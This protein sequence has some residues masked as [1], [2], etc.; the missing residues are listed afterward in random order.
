MQ[1]QPGEL[2]IYINLD[3]YIWLECR[4]RTGRPDLRRVGNYIL[5]TTGDRRDFEQFRDS[6]FYKQRPLIKT[7]LLEQFMKQRSINIE[8][9]NKF[10][11][12]FI[13][14]FPYSQFDE[15]FEWARKKL[16]SDKVSERAVDDKCK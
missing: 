3:V 10:G 15:L 11:I 2:L 8:Y 5:A 7:D 1:R 6:E 12:D 9:F 14:N 13:I 16:N 4:K